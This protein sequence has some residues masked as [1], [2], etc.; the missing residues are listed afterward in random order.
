MKIEIGE[1]LIYTWLR[2]VKGC[3]IVQTNWRPSELWSLNNIRDLEAIMDAVN[4]RFP[5]YSIFGHKKNVSLIQ[6]VGQA[7]IDVLGSC[8]VGNKIYTVDVAYHESGLNYGGGDENTVRIIKKCLRSAM[9]VYGYFNKKDAEIVFV[10]PKIHNADWPLICQ[11]IDNLENELKLL[12]YNFVFKVIC[13]QSNPSFQTEILDS[14]IEMIDNIS[15]T[16]ELFVRSVQL[17]NMFYNCTS[18]NVTTIPKIRVVTSPAN[19]PQIRTVLH[20]TNSSTANAG[21]F[22]IYLSSVVKSDG[23]PFSPS[24][25][26]NYC[27]SL[28]YSLFKVVLANH[29]LS[30]DIYDC[31]DITALKAVYDELKRQTTAIARKVKNERH[32][33]CT[34]ALREYTDYLREYAMATNDNNQVFD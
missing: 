25:I 15:D 28:N 17:L 23:T 30:E 2:H 20:R 22:K 19:K 4:K 18:N 11:N 26:N 29:G 1:S 3:Q 24:S 16:N 12:G 27:S 13:D 32:G 21:H 9:C 10:A 8:N 31:T 6:F 34:S 7:E 14:V 33:S 5:N